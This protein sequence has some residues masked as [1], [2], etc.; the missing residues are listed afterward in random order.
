MKNINEEI[1]KVEKEFEDADAHANLCEFES[2]PM[3]VR[4]FEKRIEIK[5]LKE[6]KE[7]IENYCEIACYKESFNITQICQ[8]C[9]EI[10][11]RVESQ[12]GEVAISNPADKK[13]ILGSSE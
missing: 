4:F 13:E 10:M 11:E 8:I 5:T 12:Q 7:L 2:C 1:K 9:K 6:V 3:C